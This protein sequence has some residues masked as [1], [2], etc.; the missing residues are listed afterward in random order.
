MTISKTIF[1][2]F[3]YC[4]K[5]VWLKLY[6]PE[7]LEHFALSEFEKHLLEQ[8]NEVE[9]YARNLFPG[10]V[11]VVETGE[12]ACR[13]T[14]RYMSAKVPAIFQATFIVDGFITRNDALVWDSEHNRWDMY[15]VK[16]TNSVNENTQDHNHIDDL[17]FQ[18]SVLR[19]ANIPVGRYFLVHLN[20]EYVR[21]GDLD[22]KALFIIED[23]TEKVVERLSSMEERMEAAKAYLV[24]DKEPTGECECVYQGRSNHCATFQYS[25]PEVPEYSIHDISRV[26]ASK[27]KLRTLVERKIYNINDIPDDMEFSEIQQN[28][29]MAHRRGKSILDM[30]GIAEELEKLSFPLYFLDYETFAPAI[31]VFDGYRPYQWIPFQLSLHVLRVPDGELVHIEYL[32]SETSDPSGNIAGLLEE[33]I[34]QGGTVITWNKSFEAGVNRELGLRLPAYA[35]AMDSINNMLYDLQDVFKKQHYVHPGFKGSTSIKKVIPAI[36]P[37]LDYAGLGI[38]GGAE[39]SNAWWTMVS[40]ATSVEE[41]EKI[42]HDLKIY[43]GRD[44]YNM[45]AIWKHLVELR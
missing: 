35:G 42:A 43:C 29:I 25:N 15:E 16:G 11:E 6:K 13:E 36:A 24:S 14:V 34:H 41:R 1:L 19:R 45:Y 12:E 7:L 26:G 39:A 3:L 17:T 44:T 32:H 2:D 22:T 10:G 40:P 30:D 38:Q 8:G 4:S 21:S 23:E 31:P 5:N 20:K 37:D 18:A 27:A 28:Q 33:N 9:S